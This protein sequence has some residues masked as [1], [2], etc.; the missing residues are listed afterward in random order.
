MY[1][2]Q[3]SHLVSDFRNNRKCRPRNACDIQSTERKRDSRVY[4]GRQESQI[5]GNR[6]CREPLITSSLSHIVALDT[7]NLFSSRT[8]SGL[9]RTTPPKKHSRL[10]AL[11]HRQADLGKRPKK[12]LL[13]NTGGQWMGRYQGTEIPT[14]ASTARMP[15]VIIACRWNHMTGNTT[16]IIV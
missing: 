15:C 16:K 13:I 3:L 9:Q 4:F 5:L 10:Q 7:E 12:R 14:S 6:V 2:T 8:N 11:P 1:G